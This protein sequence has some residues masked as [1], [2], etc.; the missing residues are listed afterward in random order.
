MPPAA[1]KASGGGRVGSI[2]G[3]F[4]HRCSAVPTP[5][6]SPRLPRGPYRARVGERTFEVAES[7][8]TLRVGGAPVDAHLEPTG[9]DRYTLRIGTRVHRV[10]LEG[11]EENR[12]TLSLDGQR[13]EVTVEDAQRLLLERFGLS[14]GASAAQR[15]VRSPM[16]GL[17]LAVHVQPG[18]VVEAGARLIV[19]E[20]MKM[21]NELRAAHAGTIAKVHATPGQA[22]TKGALL[23][24]FDA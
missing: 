22:V 9:P 6:A 13:V 12:L 21:E 3:V 10:V 1:S 17:V 16:P 14:D 24:E 11:R 5:D 18:E 7:G 15:E 8:G 2:L 20:A 4:C 19:L 23:L